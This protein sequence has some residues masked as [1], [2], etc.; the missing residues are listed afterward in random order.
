MYYAPTSDMNR[1]VLII[2][3]GKS[4]DDISIMPVDE[5]SG[6]EPEMDE[7]FKAAYDCAKRKGYIA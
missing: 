5:V 1:A 6:N 7:A 2:R 3:C 4:D